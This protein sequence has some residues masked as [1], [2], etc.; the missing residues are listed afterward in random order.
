MSLEQ[1]IPHQVGGAFFRL[2]VG[3]YLAFGYWRQ[4]SV[5]S[6]TQASSTTLEGK[7]MK[8]IRLATAAIAILLVPHLSQAGQIT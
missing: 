7:I 3:A 6:D 8:R 1:S 2:Q 4:I 5:D